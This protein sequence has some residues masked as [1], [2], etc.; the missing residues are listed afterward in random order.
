MP[1]T[2]PPGVPD[3][4]RVLEAEVIKL[5]WNKSSDL[6]DSAPFVGY[7]EH[8]QEIYGGVLGL[9]GEEMSRLAAEG[10]IT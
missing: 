3:G 4:V 2:Q 10:V 5:K 1:P 7:G 6:H 9:D 8:N